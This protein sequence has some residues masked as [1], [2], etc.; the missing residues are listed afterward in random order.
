MK[1]TVEISE[2]LLERTRRHARRTGRPM[3][4]LIEQ[5]LRLVLDQE[6]GTS[7]YR[8]PDFAAG[9]P[10]GENPL[11]SFSWQDLRG[12]IYGQR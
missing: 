1:T 10:K 5:G 12:E 2:A 11:E 6:S 8:L 3:R 9:D 4:A 7:K